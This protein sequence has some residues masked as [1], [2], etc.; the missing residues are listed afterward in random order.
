MTPGDE[1]EPSG[2]TTGLRVDGERVGHVAA[3]VLAAGR[4]SR[5]G[6]GPADSKVLAM[7]DGRPLIAHV[8]A[9]VAGSRLSPCVAVTGHAGDAVARALDPFEVTRVHNPDYA[10]GLA[11]SLRAGIMALPAT[12]GGAVIVLADMPL[13]RSATLDALVAAFEV[14]PPGTEAV[15]PVYEGVQ[16]NPVLLGRALFA[17]VATLRGDE[18]ARRLLAAPDR[19]VIACAVDD[20]GVAIDVDT[21]AGLRALVSGG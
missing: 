13:V 8:L 9:C 15:V 11:H 19:R 6:A 1:S 21:R 20:H 7:L 16:G 3:I 17:A 14:A 18:G 10:S 5:F 12:A 4:A 2:A